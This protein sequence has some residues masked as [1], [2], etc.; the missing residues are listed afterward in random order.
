MSLGRLFVGL[1]ML[2]LLASACTGAAAPS[3]S[4]PPPTSA[5]SGRARSAPGPSD[6]GGAPVSLKIAISAPVTSYWPVIVA[7]QA[8]LFKQEGLD[9]EIVITGGGGPTIAAVAG[10]SA[11]FAAPVYSD[12]IIATSKGQTVTS[13]APL[14]AQY[15]TDAV[16]S[17]S[18]AQALGISAT[19]PIEERVKRGSGLRI[20]VTGPGSGADKVVRF[21]LKR[22]GL[23]PEKDVSIV[24][25]GTEGQLPA[26]RAGQIDS[27]A[28][29]SPATDQA[30]AAGA[31]QWWFRPS[32]GEIPDLNG[33]T[34][35][36]LAALPQYIKDHPTVVE[37]VL[38]ATRGATQILQNEPDRAVE[39]LQDQVKGVPP[40][41]LRQILKDAAPSFP[42]SL[43]LTQKGW[44]Q[45][46]AFLADSGERVNVKFED[47]NNTEIAQRVMS[48]S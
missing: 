6:A 20:A 44:D 21:V 4:T 41:Q 26:L 40:D 16:V 12:A 33:F 19:L 29:T 5:T 35:I 9:V 32:Q 17:T 13:I 27:Y 47:A 36:T 38:R 11:Q 31:A 2:G 23:D 3:G 39:L 48:Q 24:G 18:K 10:G 7:Q 25:I 14:M 22:Y 34:Y 45:N 28:N 37:G 1:C 42:S 8:G 43:V 46:I 15:T 30:V